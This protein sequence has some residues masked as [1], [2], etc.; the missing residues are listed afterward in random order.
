MGFIIREFIRDI[1]ILIFA[2]VLFL[3]SYS[4]L[5]TLVLVLKS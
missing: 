2:Y 4:I 5:R 3:G 1:P